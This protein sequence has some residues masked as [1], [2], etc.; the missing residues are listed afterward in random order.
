MVDISVSVSVSCIGCNLPTTERPKKR[1][2]DENYFFAR[3]ISFDRRGLL[4]RPKIIVLGPESSR[5]NN[6]NSE[7]K[8]KMS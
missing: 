1:D 6:C 5:G 8:N 3:K 2:P 7:I 4:H